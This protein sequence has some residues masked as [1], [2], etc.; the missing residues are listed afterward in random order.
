MNQLT[1]LKIEG[2]RLFDHFTAA[3][4]SSFE[5]FVGA[6]GT[7]K[8]TL[9]EFLKF[10][11]DSLQLDIP[12]QIVHGSVGQHLFNNPNNPEFS[13][14]FVLN[15]QYRYEGGIL[16]P[17]GQIKVLPEK[18]S[19]LNAKT[20]FLQLEGTKGY[21]SEPKNG[22]MLRQRVGTEKPN[23]LLLSLASNPDMRTVYQ[24]REQI[25][26]WRFYSGFRIASHKIRNPVSI[27]QSPVLEEDGGN[28]SAVLHFLFT[29]HRTIFTEFER[30]LALTIPNFE[31][32]TVKARGA[33]GQILAFWKEKG[34]DQELSLADLSD[35]TLRL[36]CWAALTLQPNPPT[37]ICIDEPDQGIHPRVLPTLVG[38]FEK[39]SQ[40]TQIFLATHNSY[41]LRLVSFPALAVMR[42][43]QGQ[44]QFIKPSSSQ[45]LQAML[46]D[47]G[48]EE[49]EILHRSDELERLA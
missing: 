37:L 14:D 11:R 33:P 48:L 47:F 10:L 13:W 17:I 45:I 5:V 6:N 7:G 46:D 49:L 24:L 39:A 31:Y 22:E 19:D 3:P 35:G 44:V 42:K 1:S 12:A 41:F 28:L 43:T 29:E 25:L 40:R 15:N 23:V 34:V 38:L 21:F 8:S 9:F 18:I 30:L 4:L 32:L 2:Y 26:G 16:G 27:E 20:I 36:L